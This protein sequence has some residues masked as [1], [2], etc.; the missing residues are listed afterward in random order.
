MSILSCN[1]EV[2]RE[3]SNCPD[4]EPNRI[5][6]VAF[7]K[8]GTTFTTNWATATATQRAQNLLDAELACNAIIFR[9]VN[10]T[11]ADPTKSELPGRGRQTTLTGRT[12]HTVAVQ[13]HDYVTNQRNGFYNAL[14]KNAG[15]YDFYY[16]TENEA[17]QVN[18]TFLK[19]AAFD[20]ITDDN[21]TNIIGRVDV[22][23]QQMGNPINYEMDTDDL[24][25]CAVICTDLS[26][27]VSGVK[28]EDETFTNEVTFDNN[29]NIII[30]F[31]AQS[32]GST[33]FVDIADTSCNFEG[34]NVSILSTTLVGDDLSLN[35]VY[36]QT[37][38]V[39]DTKTLFTFENPVSSYTG[40]V[41]IRVSNPCGS[42]VQDYTFNFVVQ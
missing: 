23:W 13:D 38:Y 6:H 19:I 7:V 29:S 40:Q 14:E 5:I 3:C 31:A 9:N 8:K 11:K 34:Y 15:L 25:G 37:G 21:T 17:W 4:Y 26:G 24:E 35:L 18:D 27:N 42:V 22:T 16:M 32:T 36:P 2:S 41:V 1:D 28:G 20:P 10:G 12:T 39:A 33:I 30:P